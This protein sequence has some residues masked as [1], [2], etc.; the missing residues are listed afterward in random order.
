MSIDMGRSIVQW[1]NV[2]IGF[3]QNYDGGRRPPVGRPD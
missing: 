1:C 2:M 3:D